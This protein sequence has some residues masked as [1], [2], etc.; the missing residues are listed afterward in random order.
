MWEGGGG[1]REEN[2]NERKKETRDLSR[3]ENEIKKETEGN[4]QNANMGTNKNAQS[5]A[6]RNRAEQSRT[7][8]TVTEN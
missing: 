6:V 3:K 8:Q 2:V 1:G 5:R 7:E 4:K